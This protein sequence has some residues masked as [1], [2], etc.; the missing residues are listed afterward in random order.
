MTTTIT[1]PQTSQKKGNIINVRIDTSHAYLA[2]DSE[3]QSVIQDI[4]SEYIEGK[5]DQSLA[6]SMKKSAKLHELDSLFLS[7]VWNA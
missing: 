5:Q 2:E 7:K 6:L 4:T 1:R 3:F